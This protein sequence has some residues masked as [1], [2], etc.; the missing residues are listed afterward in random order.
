MDIGQIGLHGTAVI[1]ERTKRREV[2]N[3]SHLPAG[4]AIVQEILSKLIR[5]LVVSNWINTRPAC[6]YINVSICIYNHSAGKHDRGPL[7]FT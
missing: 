5:V 2:E 4:G 6:I 3:V 7:F 1:A